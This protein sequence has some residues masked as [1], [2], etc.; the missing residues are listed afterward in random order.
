V[1]YLLLIL[2]LAGLIYAGWRLTRLTAA[3][4]TTRVIGPDDDPDFLRRLG[5]GDNNPR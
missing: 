5:H 3:R 1:A 4:P 2:V